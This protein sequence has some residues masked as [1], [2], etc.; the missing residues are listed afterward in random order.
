MKVGLKTQGIWE[1]SL[2]LSP[3]RVNLFLIKLTFFLVDNVTNLDVYPMD[4]PTT[5]RFSI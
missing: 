1:D 2:I 5:G 4:T 3:S